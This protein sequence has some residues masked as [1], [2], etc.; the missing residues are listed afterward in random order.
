MKSPNSKTF[1]RMLCESLM[2]G[3]VSVSMFIHRGVCVRTGPRCT[4][5]TLWLYVRWSGRWSGGWRCKHTMCPPPSNAPDQTP[6]SDEA[7]LLRGAESGEIRRNTS[8]NQS[9]QI[10]SPKCPSWCLQEII[11]PWKEVVKTELCLTSIKSLKV[12]GFWSG[13]CS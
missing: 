6:D 1:S 9:H 10:W 5:A 2:H 11:E 8:K 4:A 13:T 7:G 12:T 3:P